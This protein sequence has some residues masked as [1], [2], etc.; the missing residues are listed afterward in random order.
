MAGEKY[1]KG[2]SPEE[3]TKLFSEAMAKEHEAVKRAPKIFKKGEMLEE[4][5]NE[6]ATMG[7]HE[8]EKKP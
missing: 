1:A 7:H 3:L 6:D 8:E 5:I 2:M 4:V